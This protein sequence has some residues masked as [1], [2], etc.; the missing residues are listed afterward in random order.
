MLVGLF[1]SLQQDV[2]QTQC[3]RTIYLHHQCGA[4][5]CLRCSVTNNNKSLTVTVKRATREEMPCERTVGRRCVCMCLHCTQYTSLTSNMCIR[6][7]NVSG[8][9][10]YRIH[11]GLNFY[12]HIYCACIHRCRFW[13]CTCICIVHV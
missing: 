3:L 4:N 2:T 11:A 10:K 8:I 5:L 7:H 1:T 9:H 12:S 13:L 6:T